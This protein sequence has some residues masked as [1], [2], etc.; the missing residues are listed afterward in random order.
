MSR[1]G[2]QLPRSPVKLD[3]RRRRV[4]PASTMAK[5]ALRRLS[6]LQNDAAATPVP[7]RK[8]FHIGR[9]EILDEL[10]ECLPMIAWVD[11]NLSR[12]VLSD[13]SS[14]SWGH[15]PSS[16]LV[17]LPN[18][19][20]K[21]GEGVCLVSKGGKNESLPH[22]AGGGKKMHFVHLGL[23]PPIYREGLSRLYVY[24]LDGVQLR[25]LPPPKE[26]GGASEDDAAPAPH[27]ES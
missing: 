13:G 19:A 5:R 22:P 1:T 9:P 12:Y 25:Q 18:V 4:Q 11:D 6:V 23:K 2:I 7:T 3:G 15:E 20:V 21:P 17:T 26:D 24:R 14:A 10:G 27:D 8:F 16:L